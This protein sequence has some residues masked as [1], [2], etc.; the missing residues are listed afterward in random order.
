MTVEENLSINRYKKMSASI[1]HVLAAL[2]PS[3][4]ASL[5]PHYSSASPTH[6]LLDHRLHENGTQY[7]PVVIWHGEVVCVL[8][9]THS[10]V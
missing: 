4:L 9:F 6:K 8:G 5:L 2:L 3:L 10:P 7:L 1:G